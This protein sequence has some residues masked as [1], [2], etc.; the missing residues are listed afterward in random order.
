M[1]CLSRTA[2]SDAG[3]TVQDEEVNSTSMRSLETFETFTT[4]AEM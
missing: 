3:G 4:T 2:G 1:F